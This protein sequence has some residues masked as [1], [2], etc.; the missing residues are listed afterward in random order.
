MKI[1]EHGTPGA[2]NR[3]GEAPGV[4]PDATRDRRGPEPAGQP[5]DRVSV[6]EEARTLSRLRA[7][8]GDL[9]AVRTEKVQDLRDRIERGE[10]RVDLKAVARKLLA[11]VFGERGG[12]GES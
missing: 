5:G 6:S 7:D 8:L 12:S 11:A 2:L 3:P 10:Y 1:N 4:V 9:T